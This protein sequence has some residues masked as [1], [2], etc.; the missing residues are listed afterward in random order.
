MPDGGAE[1]VRREIVSLPKREKI[2]IATELVRSFDPVTR[3]QV[4]S[5]FGSSPE[6]LQ[7]QR[8]RQTRWILTVVAF[9]IIV[10]VISVPCVA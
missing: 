9:V 1:N 7:Q 4:I 5:E 10:V 6:V 3:E 2:A 8:Q